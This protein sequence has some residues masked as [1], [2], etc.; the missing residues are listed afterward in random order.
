MQINQTTSNYRTCV[1]K[2]FWQKYEQEQNCLIG[3]N[4]FHMKWKIPEEDEEPF[5]NPDDS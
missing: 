4:F 2:I 3:Y 1:R 5:E